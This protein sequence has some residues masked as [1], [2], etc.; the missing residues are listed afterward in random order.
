M[1]VRGCYDLI[2]IRLWNLR[3]ESADSMIVL[4]EQ[5]GLRTPEDFP[6]DTLGATSL[7]FT[8]GK[9]QVDFKGLFLPLVH[10]KPR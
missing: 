2:S 8:L 5:N 3:R 6:A 4:N 1:G 10:C 7:R 9:V